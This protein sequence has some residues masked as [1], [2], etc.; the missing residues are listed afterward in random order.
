MNIS[1]QPPH[2]PKESH[3]DPKCAAFGLGFRSLLRKPKVW[4]GMFGAA[5]PPPPKLVQ[6]MSTPVMKARTLGLYIRND[7]FPVCFM[8]EKS[9][10]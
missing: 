7:M 10:A 9:Q 1:S 4:V 8:I 5:P 2:P 6:T 3:G